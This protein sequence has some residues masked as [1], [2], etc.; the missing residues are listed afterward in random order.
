MTPE[1]IHKRLTGISKDY[2]PVAPFTSDESRKRSIDAFV[3]L[4]EEW[5]TGGD[6]RGCTLAME[7]APDEEEA[8]DLLERL[9]SPSA[10]IEE[11]REMCEILADLGVYLNRK[12]PRLTLVK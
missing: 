1:Q 2:E 5:L 10:F 6:A 4:Y 9:T 8:D 7:I 11:Y 3:L 12:P